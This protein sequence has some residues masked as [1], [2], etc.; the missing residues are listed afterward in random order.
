M[1]LRIIDKDAADGSGELT[2]I[3]S[4]ANQ[5]I[6]FTVDSYSSPVSK[7]LHNLMDKHFQATSYGQP[8]QQAGEY[9]AEKLI[10]FGQFIGDEILGEDHQLIKIREII[11]EQGY[12]NLS[13]KIESSRSEFFNEPWE[14]LILPD[15]PYVLSSVTQEFTRQFSGHSVRHD[16]PNIHYGLGVSRSDETPPEVTTPS[17]A[18]PE[19]GIKPLTILTV[20]SRP[21]SISALQNESNSLK[22]ALASKATINYDLHNTSDWPTFQSRVE[23]TKN[24]VHVIH[25]DGP[26]VVD[27]NIITFFISNT[28]VE[29]TE[30]IELMTANNVGLLSV[31][32][33]VYLYEGQPIRAA[34]GLALVAKIALENG[35]G[36]IVG[37]AHITSPWISQQCFETL[38]DELAKGR[39]LSQAVVE[40]RKTLQSHKE[41]S[42]FN[43]EPVAFYPW[44]LLTHYSQQ[45]ITFFDSS[46]QSDE[47]NTL[48]HEA[49]FQGKLFGFRSEMLPPLLNQVGDGSAL[50]ILNSIVTKTH[51]NPMVIYGADG[52]GKTQIAHVV[53]LYLVKKNIVDFGFYFNLTRDEYSPSDMLQMI[54][55]VIGANVADL[56]DIENRFSR[57]H[58]SFIFDDVTDANDGRIESTASLYAFIKKLVNAGHIVLFTSKNKLSEQSIF[59]DS[60]TI[61]PLFP[62]EQKVLAT[63][64]VKEFGIETNVLTET[65][66]N[67]NLEK[68]L[69][70]VGGNPL[71]IKKVVPLL[72]YYQADSLA[73]LVTQEITEKKDQSIINNF[74]QWQWNLL[75]TGLQTLFVLCCQTPG[76]L[77]DMLMV[78][79]DQ[80]NEDSSGKALLSFLQE[81]NTTFSEALSRFEIAGFLKRFPHGRF[82]DQDCLAFIDSTTNHHLA[83]GEPNK[84]QLH[85]SQL[86]C[87]SIVFITPHLLKKPNPSVFN[88]LILNRRH[89]VEHFELLWFEQDYR[90]FMAVKQA[91]DQLLQQAKLDSESKAWI[92]DLL[93]RS[94]VP[95]TGDDISIEARLCWLALAIGTLSQDNAKS[96][97]SNRATTNN[98]IQSGIYI[99]QTWF[100]TLDLNIKGSH[101]PLFQQAAVFL[102][103]YY[104]QTSNWNMSIEVCQKTVNVYRNH[105]EWNRVIQALKSLA[106]YHLELGE[107]DSALT[108]ENDIVNTIPYEDSPPGFREKQLLDITLNRLSRN[109]PD[110]ALAML[111]LLKTT[112]NTQ[113]LADMIEGLQSDIDYQLGNYELALPYLSK[114]WVKALQ[115]DH[116]PQVEQLKS[117]LLEFQS[118]LGVETFKRIFERE[119]PEGTPLPNEKAYSIH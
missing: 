23:D 103:K 38:Y 84:A 93:D 110:N 65:S 94:D 43:P 6:E 101:L 5:T 114:I 21:E 45:S 78:T 33:R 53:S 61:K 39:A 42:L 30:I 25:Y 8:A 71:L 90:G 83:D 64:T 60:V 119:V 88:N 3:F 52:F 16:F 9:I 76:L 62:I 47:P 4:G 40:T 36:N 54:A 67:Q 104:Q 34:K 69:T 20:V 115:S 99:W 7:N 29:L 112:G 72:K 59:C 17:N 107:K 22:C 68:L 98:K 55:P 18:D 108:L 106:R 24:P 37:L 92:L 111:T 49:F 70:S 100:K 2:I 26:V 63:H 86:I 48:A 91:F 31:D 102:E 19:V 74:Y 10:T 56:A 79:A 85:F 87:E 97:N 105:N 66:E 81:S 113:H 1:L 15:S 14:T 82:V 46:Q 58:C 11:E 12:S 96:N 13:V 75:P 118:N 95:E 117:R 80:N 41:L 51:K 73:S 50:T 89:W 28:P 44:P 32:A 109:D 35:L 77:L 116:A 57:L 27:N